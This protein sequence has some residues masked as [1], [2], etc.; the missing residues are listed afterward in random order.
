[1]WVGT[2]VKKKAKKFLTICICIVLLL[3]VS[4]CTNEATDEGQTRIEDT[5]NYQGNA[6]V[7]YTDR[8]TPYTR[9]IEHKHF[10]SFGQAVYDNPKTIISREYSTEWGEG[11][12]P[13]YPVN[14]EKNTALYHLLNLSQR[15]LYY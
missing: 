6:V 7:N 12:E 5:A 9:V 11:M 13:F 10:E 8:E 14:D 1:M 4:G 3:T 15:T 2:K